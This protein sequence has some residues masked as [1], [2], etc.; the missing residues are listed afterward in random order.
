MEKIGKEDGSKQGQVR[1]DTWMT[2]VSQM[3]KGACKRLEPRVFAWSCCAP[4]YVLC[5]FVYCL[6]L[7]SVGWRCFSKQQ[8]LPNFK[9]NTTRQVLKNANCSSSNGF[10]PN[11][12][13]MTNLSA[14]F[15]ATLYRISIP[16]SGQP[17]CRSLHFL[18]TVVFFFDELV[19]CDGWVYN[20]VQS[21]PDTRHAI[22]CILFSLEQSQVVDL[23]VLLRSFCVQSENP[24]LRNFEFS[25]LSLESSSASP[26]RSCQIELCLF[27]STRWLPTELCNL[28]L[29]AIAQVSL[30]SFRIFL[31]LLFLTY[32]SPGG[33]FF[34]VQKLRD[35]LRDCC[36]S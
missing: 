15:H 20:F 16:F 13:T 8:K 33:T 5:L 28:S 36:S 9:K 23:V 12:M 24:T 21:L 7:P 30:D 31:D 17:R 27:L 14:G 32:V 6:H 11:A 3:R 18:R 26:K 22:V 19:D 1:H 10:Y 2:T 35:W 29:H 25:Q 4:L 34:V